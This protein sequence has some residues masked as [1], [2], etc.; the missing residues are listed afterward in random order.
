MKAHNKRELAKGSYKLVY[1]S[2]LIHLLYQCYNILTI[3][4]LQFVLFTYMSLTFERVKYK[5]VTC[6]LLSCQHSIL[7]ESYVGK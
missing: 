7:A 5:Y 3:H 2:S 6:L 1:D 4:V